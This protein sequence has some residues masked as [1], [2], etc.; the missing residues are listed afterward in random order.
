[1]THFELQFV[2]HID[3]GMR[4]TGVRVEFT[5]GRGGNA[6]VGKEDVWGCFDSAEAGIVDGFGGKCVA[7]DDG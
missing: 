3:Q 2:A 4:G 7:G 5:V 1:M 6:I